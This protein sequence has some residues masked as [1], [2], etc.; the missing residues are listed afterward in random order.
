MTR[1]AWLLTLA[2]CG[3]FVDVPPGT[4]PACADTCPD[5]SAPVGIE[6]ALSGEAAPIQDVT[7]TLACLPEVPCVAPEIAVYDGSLV[8]CE[9]PELLPDPAFLDFGF[10]PP[11]GS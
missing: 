1:V 5:G 9:D 7:C 10:V 2:G 6:R 8:R 3:L 4:S 11:E